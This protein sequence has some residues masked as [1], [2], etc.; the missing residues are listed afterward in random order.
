MIITNPEILEYCEE[1]PLFDIE[2]FLVNV[3]RT[4]RTVKEQ[5]NVEQV[6]TDDLT[7]FKESLIQDIK[8]LSTTIDNDSVEK[9]SN[10]MIPLVSNK[11]DSFS[12][13]FNQNNVELKNNIEQIKNYILKF[14]NQSKGIQTEIAL[15]NLLEKEYPTCEIVHVASRDQKGKTDINIIQEGFPKVLLD[16]KNYKNTV[17]R[18]EVEKFE[19]DLL[20]SGDH[21]ILYAPFSGIYNKRHFQ[22][23]MINSSISIYLSNCG[24]N[25]IDIKN[26]IEIIY[27]LDDYLK[28]KDSG[29]KLSSNTLLQINNLLSKQI[30]QIKN[31]REHLM[32]S[33]KIC[34]VSILNDIKGLLTL[35]DT[36][37]NTCTRCNKTFKTAKPYT[38]HIAKCTAIL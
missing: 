34:D 12:Y 7:A 36:K 3:I 21:G 23:N 24:M 30:E 32:D 29:I 37:T 35:T 31:I 33:L 18:K 15:K 13:I 9:I 8:G 10:V 11:L 5:E 16:S 2:D 28:K 4:F 38:N 14:E 20:E 17:P 6:F 25:V 19:R 27:F 26:A 22:I 1:N